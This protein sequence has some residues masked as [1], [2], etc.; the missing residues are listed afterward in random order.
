MQPARARRPGRHGS[1]SILLLLAAVLL[2]TG[3]G[4]SSGSGGSAGG[5]SSSGS[6]GAAAGKVLL[7]TS[8]SQPE[9]DALLAAYHAAHPGVKVGVFRAPTG[10]LNARIAAEQRSG[11]IRGDVLLLSDPLSM[12]QFAAQK[13]LRRWSPPELAAVPAEARSD[14]FWGVTTSDV[15]VVNQPGYDVAT[16]QALTG[17]RFRK[18]VALADP[19]FAGSAFGALGYFALADGFGLDYYRRLKA[20]GAVQVQAPGDVITGVAEGRFKAGMTLDFL[21]RAA[22]KQGSPIKIS[23]PAPGAVRLYAPVAVF[24]DTKNATAA[25][26]FAGFLLTKPAQRALAAQDRHPIRA[27]V[28]AAAP[29]VTEVAPDWP[30]IFARQAE[31]RTGYR[32][33]FGG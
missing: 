3:C 27:D 24:A 32:G 16:W 30:A 14:T 31:L 7:Y 6:A 2:L 11:G 25:E 17:P 23:V 9:V 13:L 20:N 1:R 5:A 26:S 33:I 22:I 10:Q 18:G 29:A 28:P 15:V 12:Q 8:Y 19:S 21:A 4:G